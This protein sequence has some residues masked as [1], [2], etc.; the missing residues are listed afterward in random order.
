MFNIGK[1]LVDTIIEYGKKLLTG[2]EEEEF[3]DSSLLQQDKTI[4]EYRAEE[5]QRLRIEFD[6]AMFKIAERNQEAWC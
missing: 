6:N 3:S 1:S 2:K 4:E 5:R